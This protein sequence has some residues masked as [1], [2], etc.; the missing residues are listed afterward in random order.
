MKRNERDDETKKRKYY[1]ILIEYQN[2]KNR[3]L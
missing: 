2:C 1:N 3:A